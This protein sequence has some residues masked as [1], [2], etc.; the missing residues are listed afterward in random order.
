MK[1][2]KLPC[3]K[4]FTERIAELSAPWCKKNDDAFN[5]NQGQSLE[6]K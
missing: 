4:L 5:E 2:I 6:N 3:T 1:K